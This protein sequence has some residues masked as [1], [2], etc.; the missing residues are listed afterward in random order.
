MVKVFGEKIDSLDYIT[1]K[2]VYAVI[3][4]SVRDKV[5]TVHNSRGDY[6]LP[7][8]GIENNENHLSCL[9]REMLEETGFKVIIDSY[10][11]NAMRY[12]QSIKDEPLLNDGYFYLAALSDKIQ[13]PIE[14]D[15]YFKWINIRNAEQLFIHDHHYWAVKQGL[16]LLR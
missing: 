12:F 15:H 1:K 5:F 10:I 16:E 7:G 9:E 8:G 2:G 11:G 13:E 6:F 3:F 4:N 14:D